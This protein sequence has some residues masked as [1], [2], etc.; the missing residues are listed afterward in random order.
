MQEANIGQPAKMYI[1]NDADEDD[2]EEFLEGRSYAAP[3]PC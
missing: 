3:S 1:K 2:Y